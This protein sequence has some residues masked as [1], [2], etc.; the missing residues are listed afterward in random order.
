LICFVGDAVESDGRERNRMKALAD[1][2]Y[3][4]AFGSRAVWKVLGI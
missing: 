1:D 3:L 2:Y 4:L